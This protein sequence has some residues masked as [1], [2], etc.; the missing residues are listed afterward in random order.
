MRKKD[1]VWPIITKDSEKA[2]INQLH[3]AISIYDRSG[4]YLELE[5]N[6]SKYH[7]R[8]YALTTNSGTTAIYS[9]F[10]GASFVPGDEV[11]CPVYTFFATVTPLLFIGAIPVFVDCNEDGNINPEKIEGK[12]TKKTKAIII[13][14]MWGIPCDMDKIV[15]IA[16]KYKLKLFEDCSHAHGATYKGKTVGSFSDASAWSLQGQKIITGGELGI[17]TTN[18]PEIYYR[19]LLLGHFNKRSLQEIPKNNQYY[20]YAV[21]G[22]GLKLRANPLGVALANE[23][24]SKLNDYLK[25]KRY[26]A[27]KLTNAIENMNGLKPPVFE[28]IKNPAW[29]AYVFQFVPE[30]MNISIDKFYKEAIDMGATELDRPFSTCPLTHFEIFK[31]PG[32]LFKTYTAKNFSKGTFNKAEKFYN[33]ALKLPVWTRKSDEKYVDKYIKIFTTL[34]LKYG[35]NNE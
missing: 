6:F 10:V 24:F 9:M 27:K 26:F 11:I 19:A 15:K 35:K 13:T 22:M 25:Q 20:K 33:N 30:K 28:N 34:C 12:I 32:F 14:H 16:K 17:L 31:T 29:Y 7:R 5:N 3:A 18:D 23:Q 1:F 2:V 21:T 8:K 4:I